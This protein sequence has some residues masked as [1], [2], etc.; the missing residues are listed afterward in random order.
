MGYRSSK[1]FILTL[2][3][4]NGGGRAITFEVTPNKADKVLALL[5]PEIEKKE[6]EVKATSITLE[7]FF[8]EKN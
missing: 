1:K 4:V 2:Q 7:Q 3:P 6:K 5:M 8:I